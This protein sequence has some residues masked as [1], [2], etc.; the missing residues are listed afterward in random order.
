MKKRTCFNQFL[1]VMTVI[2]MIS[3]LF[4]GVAQA[5][6]DEDKITVLPSSITD[7][8]QFE[9]GR[10]GSWAFDGDSS[11][12]YPA[13]TME[14]TSAATEVAVTAVYDRDVTVNKIKLP[15]RVRWSAYDYTNNT[16]IT[17]A[18]VILKLKIT[19]YDSNDEVVSEQTKTSTIASG[20]SITYSTNGGNAMWAY[21]P[22]IALSEFT[23]R[24]IK[25]EVIKADTQN[26]T[27]IK[28]IELYNVTVV[29]ELSFD[30]LNPKSS[31]V[32]INGTDLD[33]AD[34]IYTLDGSEPSASNGFLYTDAINIP[35][36]NVV[37]I[38]AATV[39]NGI[40]TSDILSGTYLNGTVTNVG[41]QADTTK[42]IE[43]GTFNNSRTP[44]YAF[45]GISAFENVGQ[46]MEWSKNTAS[47]SATV[48]YDSPITADTIVIP[49]RLRSNAYNSSTNE[50]ISTADV[51]MTLTLTVYNDDGTVKGTQNK[52]TVLPAGSALTYTNSAMWAVL[53]AIQLDEFT[54]NKIK[55]E[56]FTETP[57]ATAECVDSIKEF[58]FYDTTPITIEPEVEFTEINPKSSIIGLSANALGIIKYTLDGS[59]PTLEHGETYTSAITL[60]T[61]AVKVKAALFADGVKVS[62]TV[63]KTYVSGA[64]T[65][66]GVQTDTSKITYG[67]TFN[68]S[69]TPNYAFDGVSSF[70]G[71]GVVMEWNKNT[72]SAWV[73]VSYD[74]AITAD[75]IVVP[76]RLRNSTYPFEGTTS[77][78]E[79][80]LTLT[81]T[82]YEDDGTTVKSTQNKV[83]VLPIGS[84]LTYQDGA[85]WANLPAIELDEFTSNKI[86]IEVFTETPQ[87]TNQHVDSIK[88]FEFYDTLKSGI[89]DISVGAD[90]ATAS[91]YSGVA[92]TA[93]IIFAAY[94]TGSE[95]EVVSFEQQGVNLLAGNN[96]VTSND[97]EFDE[98]T[99]IKV[100]VWKDLDNCKAL[101]KSKAANLN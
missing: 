12:S 14:W 67:G 5:S 91:I 45:D 43:T 68:N 72:S 76:I 78:K 96:S 50:E 52:V 95:V 74:E 6:V 3:S 98:A 87:G 57:Q 69:R 53:P 35:S 30:T 21:M 4:L 26:V 64:V 18:D 59:E 38:K 51:K 22:D 61:G 73:T 82:V 37:K 58:E 46:T 8:A 39:K 32:G 1:S 29:P 94:K 71:A 49:V 33:G 36:G 97:F 100:F 40:V 85:T 24:K 75:T 2:T 70:S 86:K 55:V 101:F 10:G 34:I 23:A 25:F 27:S 44:K 80:K 54:S 60:P 81:L 63:S 15:I 13:K 84:E 31:T 83:T 20:T 77:T 92:Q 47:A 19:A 66:L 42:I 90:S 88:E 93:Y 79:V 41:I 62:E 48:S 56:V 99:R 28:E 89:T 16:P 7:S 17:T 11:F 65:N 9:T